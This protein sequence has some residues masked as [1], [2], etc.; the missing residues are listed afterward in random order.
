MLWN[1]I[2]IWDIRYY[3]SQR[4]LSNIQRLDFGKQMLLKSD[5]KELE[6]YQMQMDDET[7]SGECIG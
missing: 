3:L 1:R 2:T 5:V 6:A 4:H 7:V